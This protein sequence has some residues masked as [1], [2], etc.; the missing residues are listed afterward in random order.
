MMKRTGLGGA[1]E[2]MMAFSDGLVQPPGVRGQ[3]RPRQRL[4]AGDDV[5]AVASWSMFDIT[6][7]LM[8]AR[9]G[10]HQQNAVRA[11]GRGDVAARAHQHVNVALHRQ[12]VDLARSGAACGAGGGVFE[13]GSRLC[14]SVAVPVLQ[15]QRGIP[16]KSI[17]LR[18]APR[19]RGISSAPRFGFCPGRKCGTAFEIFSSLTVHG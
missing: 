16:D 6:F 11:D 10:I 14:G 1:G 7:V 17:P 19:P 5:I 2:L 8:S 3:C 4:G 9:P 18:R 13:I 15:L 12:H